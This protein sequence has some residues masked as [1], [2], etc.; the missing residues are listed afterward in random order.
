MRAAIAA[1]RQSS[2]DRARG[3]REGAEH[4][5]LAAAFADCPLDTAEP[6]AARAERLLDDSG[7]AGALL[8]PLVAALAADPFFEAPFRIARD[9]LRTGAVLFDCPAASISAS[10]VDA[11]ALATRP[12]PETIVF[13]GRVSVTR[14]CKAG[15]ATLARWRTDPL[16]PAFSAT[17]APPCVPLPPLA[18]GDG[19]LHRADG[20]THAHH[21]ERAASDVVTLCATIRA[22]GAPLVRE[23]RIQDGALVRVASADDGASRT[24][25]LLTFLSLSG[26]ADAGDRF[27][28]ATHDPAFHLRWAAMRE[29]LALDAAAALPRLAEMAA[30][31]PNAEVR[32]A[33]TLTLVTVRRRIEAGCR[34]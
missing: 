19:D 25:M 10:V 3:W 7:L 5:A 21:V 6:A 23:H 11:S 30:R 14:Y 29:W 26:R 13:A 15:G 1:A 22:G 32:A 28:A 20:Q 16:T 8:A 17:D 33:A 9:G 18:L 27:E 12:P 4:R 34:A 24:E 31:D 2:I